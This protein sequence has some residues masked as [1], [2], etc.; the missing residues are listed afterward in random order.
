[1][2]KFS[3]YRM[4]LAGHEEDPTLARYLTVIPPRARRAAYAA[5]L[6]PLLARILYERAEHREPSPAPQPVCGRSPTTTPTAP[7]SWGSPAAS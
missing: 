1:M 6:E 7:P 4:P 5:G 3:P 2:G